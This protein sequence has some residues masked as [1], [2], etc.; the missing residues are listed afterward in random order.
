VA[1]EKPVGMVLDSGALLAIESGGFRDQLRFAHLHALPIRFSAGVLAQTWR[2]GSRG[3]RLAAFMKQKIE[4]VALNTAE[5]RRV[6]EFIAK[7]VQHSTR[8][9]IVDA[10]T[11]ML[12]LSTRSL[13]YTSDIGDLERYGVPKERLVLV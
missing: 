8:P 4:V 3:A 1:K 7:R 9:D 12:A 6:G 10:H 13:V 5:A 2:G 11:A